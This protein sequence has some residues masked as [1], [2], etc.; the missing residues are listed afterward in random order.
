MS[1]P[2][3]E[4]EILV[5]KSG[6]AKL[7]LE[8]YSYLFD[9]T[10]VP[11]K[12][13]VKKGVTIYINDDSPC[14][15]LKDNGSSVDS[16]SI[17][18]LSGVNS[19]VSNDYEKNNSF[20][21]LDNKNDLGAV[22]IISNVNSKVSNDYEKNNSLSI[23]D[24]DRKLFCY[25][26]K[27]K[28]MDI[29]R[30]KIRNIVRDTSPGDDDDK[31]SDNYRFSNSKNR[32]LD[33]KIMMGNVFDDFRDTINASGAISMD[34][35]G[36]VKNAREFRDKCLQNIDNC[37][38][39]FYDSQ[40]QM[41][42][43]WAYLPDRYYDESKTI[44]L[45][46]SRD[47]AKLMNDIGKNENGY[48]LESLD[49]G[50]VKNVSSNILRKVNQSFQKS[51]PE[52]LRY[53]AYSVLC[54]VIR[55]C[56]DMRYKDVGTDKGEKTLQ[57]VIAIKRLLSLEGTQEAD[58]PHGGNKKDRFIDALDKWIERYTKVKEESC[59]EEDEFI[60]FIKEEQEE[61]KNTQAGLNL[62]YKNRGLFASYV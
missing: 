52:C 37:E 26:P 34:K 11:N 12:V 38:L 6:D 42:S 50:T 5:V 4:S 19:K 15:Y 59:K 22:P 55:E 44:K 27:N 23:F 1:V 21:K 40:E 57:R 16:G 58:K 41:K 24:S 8:K 60:D 2:V 28:N 47:R 17:P 25:Y 14:T 43:E 46:N 3:K 35:Q 61:I 30:Y 9:E 56:I 13:K 53:V 7:L 10:G 49:H 62:N 32:L 31:E 39:R 54:P 18:I 29:M 33:K 36:N 45:N 51:V 48:V 20:T